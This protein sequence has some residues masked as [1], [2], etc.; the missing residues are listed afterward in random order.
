M[1]EHSLHV[2][3]IAHVPVTDVFIKVTSIVERLRHIGDPRDVPVADVPVGSYGRGLV[4]KPQVDR[5][6][7]IG[8][9]E[10]RGLPLRIH[11]HAKKGDQAQEPKRSRECKWAE[12]HS[13]EG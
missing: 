2:R 8:I 3:H 6:L 11:S 4:G 9:V 10:G 5:G 1:P 12:Q 13:A 7:K